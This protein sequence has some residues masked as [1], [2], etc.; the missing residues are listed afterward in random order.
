MTIISDTTAIVLGLDAA[1]RA[2][3]VPIV[4]VSV[5]TPADRT[6]WKV[7]YDP[8]ATAQQR[9][10]GA[11]LVASFD[12]TAPSVLANQLDKEAMAAMANVVKALLAEM[13]E[14]KLGRV[15]TVADIPALQAMFTRTITYYKFIVNNGL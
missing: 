4:N 6:T 3:G 12:P 9:I 7:V 10:D 2:A 1:L 8:S 15:L 5:G 13:L 11:A 14:T